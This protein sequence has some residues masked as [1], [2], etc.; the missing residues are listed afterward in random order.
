MCRES[1]WYLLPTSRYLAAGTGYLGSPSLQCFPYGAAF[2]RASDAKV[3]GELVQGIAG[4]TPTHLL[5]PP[6]YNIWIFALYGR[7]GPLDGRKILVQGVGTFCPPGKHHS[8]K[9]Y[10]LV[11]CCRSSGQI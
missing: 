5:P 2:F 9:K 4:N 8:G 3:V 10:E 11:L 7:W 1:T 6:P